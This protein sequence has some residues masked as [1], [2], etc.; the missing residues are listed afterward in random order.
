MRR[1][2]IVLLVALLAL[3]ATGCGKPDARTR[4]RIDKLEAT[5]LTFYEVSLR[6]ATPVS[7]KVQDDGSVSVRYDRDNGY[8]GFDLTISKAIYDPQV[9]K[10]LRDEGATCSWR[11]GVL[12]ST[13]EEQSEVAVDVDGTRLHIRGLVTEQDHKILEDAVA[14]LQK[15][16]V[17]DAE[18][19]ASY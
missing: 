19:L 15:A 9:C 12:R 5:G 1:F 14:A 8:Y 13:F 11:D 3:V 16:K 2:L 6:D 10:P 4:T 7:E 17:V 18:T